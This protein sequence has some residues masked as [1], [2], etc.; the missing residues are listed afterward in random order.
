MVAE[1]VNVS[2]SSTALIYS[3]GSIKVSGL[4][5]DR[6]HGRSAI[7]VELFGGLDLSNRSVLFF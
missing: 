2:P 1:N 7:V 3:F 6:I 4:V 5:A